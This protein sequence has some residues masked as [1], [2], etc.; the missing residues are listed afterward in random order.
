MFDLW[1]LH[2]ANRVEWY[3]TY[4]TIYYQIQ[5]HLLTIQLKSKTAS[6]LPIMRKASSQ[7]DPRGLSMKTVQPGIASH[8][9]VLRVC[10]WTKLWI[11]KG[12]AQSS[13]SDPFWKQGHI[14]D[15][16][17]PYVLCHRY[18]PRF[19]WQFH[20]FSLLKKNFFSSPSQVVCLL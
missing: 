7:N 8:W 18:L 11:L 2:T 4:S 9:D 17:W 3:T 10:W 12:W 20:Y 14:R 19:L 5:N 16:T 1:V 15:I 6:D 13:L